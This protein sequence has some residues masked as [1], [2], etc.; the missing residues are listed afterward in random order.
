MQVILSY[1]QLHVGPFHQDSEL[2]I[3]LICNDLYLD[4]QSEAIRWR[5]TYFA[6]CLFGIRT[7]RKYLFTGSELSMIKLHSKLREHLFRHTSALWSV[8]VKLWL[9]HSFSE[10]FSI[11]SNLKK[12]IILNYV[13]YGLPLSS[14]FLEAHNSYEKR[15]KI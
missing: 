9:E 1:L 11:S 4:F 12:W 8:M 14:R 6:E 10:F 3:E 7:F 2:N 15:F 13:T 5:M